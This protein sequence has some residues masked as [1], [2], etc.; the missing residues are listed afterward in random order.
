MFHRRCVDIQKSSDPE[1]NAPLSEPIRMDLY[2]YHIF[3]TRL[4]IL[5]YVCSI[6]YI[7]SNTTEIFRTV[8]MLSLHILNENYSNRSCM[9]FKVI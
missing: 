4:Y 3:P 2:D 6:S 7:K 9:L 1:C 5:M 8:S